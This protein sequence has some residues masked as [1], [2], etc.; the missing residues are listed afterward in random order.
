MEN[1][2]KYRNPEPVHYALRLFV[3]G[4]A[5][6]SRI[7]KENLRRLLRDFPSE[8]VVDLDIVDVMDNPDAALSHG[9]F[10]TP[11]LQVIEPGLETLIFGNLSDQE[12]LKR[13]FP[14]KV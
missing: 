5:P 14:E 8:D 6:N 10:V 7:A 11:A 3:A 12:V 4:N 1:S 9:V 2:S 13:L